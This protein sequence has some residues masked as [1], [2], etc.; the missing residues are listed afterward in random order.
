MK[1]GGWGVLGYERVKEGEG[2]VDEGG[3]LE[4]W[5]CLMYG[6]GVRGGEGEGVIGG[7]NGGGLGV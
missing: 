7:G 2:V 1:V 4:E 5:E 6:G 3:V